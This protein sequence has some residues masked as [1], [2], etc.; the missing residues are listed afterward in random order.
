MYLPP[1]ISLAF[2]AGLLI[3]H[4]QL[5]NRAVEA[6][7][8]LQAAFVQRVRL[9]YPGKR[10]I[11]IDESSFDSRTWARRYGRSRRGRRTRYR[12]LFVRGERWTLLPV[13]SEGG[14]LDYMVYKGSIDGFRY[15]DFLTNTLV[16]ALAGLE[17]VVL[18]LDNCRIHH[19]QEAKDILTDA[20]IEVLYLPPYSPTLNPIELMFSQVKS[21]V[22]GLPLEVRTSEPVPLL[23]AAAMER[24]TAA[25]CAG[26]YKHS[27]EYYSRA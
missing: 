24:V 14:V 9:A 21:G 20:G 17:D 19:I 10:F 5:T 1:F 11:F 18:V 3:R 7:R 6:D 2:L 12:V 4:W 23:I 13:M 26:C 16:P 15:I 27:C 8:E 22:R 25:D